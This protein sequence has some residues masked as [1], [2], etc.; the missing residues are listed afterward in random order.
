MTWSR[1]VSRAAMVRAASAGTRWRRV[2]AGL[3]TEPL[4]VVVCAGRR[5]LGGCCSGVG[6]A[7]HGADLR[8][9]LA[10]GEAVRGR[11]RASTADGASC[12]RLV[13][14]S[15]PPT[16]V[17]PASTRGQ[18]VE[19]AVAEESG[20]H[21]VQGGGESFGDAGQLG[22]DLGELAI[23]RPQR[24]SAVLWTIASNRSTRS[25]WCRPCRS[26]GRRQ[27]EH[28]QVIGRC[29]DPAS[30]VEACFRVR[31]GRCVAPKKVRSWA[32]RAGSGCGR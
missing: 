30:I 21:A 13:F 27:L 2:R 25:P 23:M 26:A 32:P 22:D 10:D 8:G 1:R 9:E 4:A 17:A 12:I 31:R 14:R 29:L 28:G 20:I 24:S 11:A 18:L 5:P 16:R 15:T 7:G 3:S 6:G 19:D